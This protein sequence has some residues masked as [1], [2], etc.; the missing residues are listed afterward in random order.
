MH[1]KLC[2]CF[3]FLCSLSPEFWGAKR[4]SSWTLTAEVQVF[5]KD[6]VCKDP[7]TTLEFFKLILTHLKY[8]VILMKL[9]QIYFK[10]SEKQ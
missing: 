6:P 7:A 1:I 10:S 8:T 9:I 4:A 5:L 2:C 3:Y